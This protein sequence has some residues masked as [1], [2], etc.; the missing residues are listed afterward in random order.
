MVVDKIEN[1]KTYECTHS[2]FSKAFEFIHKTDFSKLEDGK[3]TIENE[4]I[5]AIIQQYNTKDSKEAKLEA[6]RR[7]IDIQ[8]IHSGVELIGVATLKNQKIIS[9]DP[10][11]DLIF[12]EGEA[13]FIKINAGMF[14]IFFPE[15]MHMPG[16]NYVKSA[17]VKKVVIKV[18]VK[19]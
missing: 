1:S 11:K 5:F 17:P 10:E 18:N 19:S 12:Y 8:Y 7:Y 16:I 9:D 2:R 13:S 3:Y 14:A 4:D 15:D 6:H